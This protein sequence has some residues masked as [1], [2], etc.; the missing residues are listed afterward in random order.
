MHIFN[1][2]LTPTLFCQLAPVLVYITGPR[3]KRESNEL[4]SAVMV[5]FLET[6]SQHYSEF[7]KLSNFTCDLRIIQ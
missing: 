3:K 6:L 1:E 7:I 5:Q 4:I 2:A